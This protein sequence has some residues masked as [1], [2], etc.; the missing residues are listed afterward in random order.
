MP[1][2]E[3]SRTSPA[4]TA[5][6]SSP[7]RRDACSTPSDAVTRLSQFRD[8]RRADA[9]RILIVDT[10]YADFL[11]AHYTRNPGLESR[12]YAEQWRALM[13]TFFGT[14]DSYSHHLGALG[15]DA[16]EVVA[17]CTQLQE[18]WALEH[19]TRRRILSLP[20][21]G[22]EEQIVLAQAREF[23]ADVVYVQNL[24]Y[25]S[26][27]TLRRLR[28]ISGLVVGQIASE[29]PTAAKLRS[30][31]LVLTS[32]PHFVDRFRGLG[33]ASE[34]LR[35]G[36]DERIL[37][38]L[39]DEPR[40]QHGAVFVGALNRTQHRSGN[41]LLEGAART[42]PIDFWGY[43]PDGWPKDSPI[44]TCYRGEAWGLEMFRVLHASRVALNRHIDVAGENANN[45]RL[46][47][48]TG[49]GALLVTDAKQN[50]HELFEQGR[51]VVTY[52][53]GDDLAE[54]VR[55][56]LEHDDERRAIAQAGQ[57][58]TLREH[59]YARRMEELASILERVR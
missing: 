55:Y 39:A 29:P 17:N 7:R 23:G 28:R 2:A 48:A 43:N 57:A 19:G 9:V 38:R 20:R 46:Y 49:V 35:I 56:Y 54:T 44:R 51:E 36:F 22:R 40:E 5:G 41:S 24:R 16:H 13:D 32:F 33:V 1:A 45:M 4:A 21:R 15:H 42:V 11:D 47:E 6:G 10:C 30:F 14:A 58:R 53:E 3:S 50:L 34:Y 8:A 25:L 12:P 27:R 37:D 26:R 52:E 31:D 59:T 18:T